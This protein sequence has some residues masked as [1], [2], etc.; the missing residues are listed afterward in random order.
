MSIGLRKDFVWAKQNEQKRRKAYPQDLGTITK[1]NI[2]DPPMWTS[3]E[4]HPNSPT[5]TTR[6]NKSNLHQVTITPTES[7]SRALDGGKQS[8]IVK[9]NMPLQVQVTTTIND[10][11]PWKDYTWIKAQGNSRIRIINESKAKRVQ[12]ITILITMRSRGL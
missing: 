10:H 4:A 7:I 8:A 12:V 11:I 2:I 9:R 3:K 5:P 1:K 6:G